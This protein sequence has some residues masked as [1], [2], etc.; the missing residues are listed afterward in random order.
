MENLLKLSS[1]IEDKGHNLVTEEATKNGLIMPFIANILGYDVFDVDQVVP[2]YIADIGIKK[3]EKVDYALLKDDEVQ[4]LIECKKLGEPLKNAHANQL[5][6]YF[7]VTKCRIAILTNGAEYQFFTD[8]DVANVMDNKPFMSLDL[9]DIDDHVVPEIKKLRRDT[10]DI[11]AIMSVASE[12]KYLNQIKKQ[13][14]GEF[15]EPSE[16]LVKFLTG[17]VYEGRITPAVKA[18]FTALTKK[19]LKQFLNDSINERLKTALNSDVQPIDVELPDPAVATEQEPDKSEIVTTVEEIE[20]YNIVK[21]I[22]RSEVEVT[23][24]CA[25]DTLS[26]FGILLDDNNRKPLCRLHFNRAQKYI[27]IIGEDR[28]ETRHPIDS[29]DDIFKFSDQL[30]EVLKR[31]N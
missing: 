10:V 11:E 26:Y 7:T 14:K 12:L 19:A 4:I 15:T 6:R 28:K 8:L 17:K 25:R 31:Y 29:M 5:L 13:L 3:G 9:R 20:G 18:Q 21:A 22:L 30:L 27:G 23:R 1:I 2:E 24:V 16:E